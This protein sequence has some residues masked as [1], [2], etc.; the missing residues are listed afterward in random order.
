MA[1]AADTANPVEAVLTAETDAPLD[2]AMDAEAETNRVALTDTALCAAILTW[3][4]DTTVAPM[5]MPLVAAMLTAGS[6]DPLE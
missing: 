2:A 1:L 6:N 3:T 5:A 4:C